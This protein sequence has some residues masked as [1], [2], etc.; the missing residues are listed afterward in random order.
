MHLFNPPDK[1][2]AYTPLDSTERA[3]PH[4]KKQQKGG[5]WADPII[6]RTPWPYI[7]G[8]GFAII[9]GLFW[10]GVFEYK[11]EILNFVNAQSGFKYDVI[12]ASPIAVAIVI[13][14]VVVFFEERRRRAQ[15]QKLEQVVKER[16]E[17]LTHSEKRY[18]ALVE[19]STAITYIDAMD[20]ES[21]N[22][23]TSPQIETLLGYS[24]EEWS[25]DHHLWQ[26]IIYPEDHDRV[27]KENLRTNATGE[28]F[29]MDYRVHTK[30]GRVIWVHDEAVLMDHGKGKAKDWQGVIYNITERKV[31]EEQLRFLS[32]HD[33]LTGIHNRA[34]FEEEMARLENSR[35]FPVS[36]IIGDVDKLKVTNDRYGHDAGD[37]V[38]KR[39]AQILK[40]SFR[41][42]DVVARTGGDEFAILLPETDHQ[43]AQQAMERVQEALKVA[44]SKWQEPGLSISMGTATC[45]KGTALSRV[46][47]LADDQMYH[48]KKQT[49]STTES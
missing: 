7:V 9:V 5:K 27:Q 22:L 42:E 34:Y 21:S 3:E 49:S 23:Y 35:G 24:C 44:A 18:R 2:K 1:D 40:E 10:W 15:M 20:E 26:K 30:D 39:V 46:M 41:S 12:I 33:P 11:Q 8:S 14:F 13:I 43:A 17:E 38:L 37:N 6:H 19:Q 29:S 31:M 32:T 25:Q 28:P 36:I 4:K 48:G 45:E 47:K 16:T